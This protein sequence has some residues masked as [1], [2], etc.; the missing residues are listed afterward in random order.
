MTN[1]N[2]LK[3]KFFCSDKC[4]L[5][6]F[7]T[8]PHA[9]AGHQAVS[10]PRAELLSNQYWGDE[11][12]LS[13]GLSRSL[14]SPACLNPV[15]VGNWSLL[16]I[17]VQT[18]QATFKSLFS[19]FILNIIVDIVVTCSV[20]NWL[21]NWSCTIVCNFPIKPKGVKALRWIEHI[22]GTVLTVCL[23]VINLIKS[24]QP[25]CERRVIGYS[26]CIPQEN[27]G[28]EKLSNLPKVTQL[29]FK[30]KCLELP[31]LSSLPV[32]SPTYSSC[33]PTVLQSG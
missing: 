31:L 32:Y 18:S 28:T 19:G 17:Q 26:H 13:G 30:F 24:S 20:Y 1:F 2:P 3:F 4:L 21:Y 33:I 27:R 5:C 25:Q 11:L 10:S 9:C 16:F 23:E 22:Q 14:V 7:V 8:N 15:P 6:C 29:G 12:K